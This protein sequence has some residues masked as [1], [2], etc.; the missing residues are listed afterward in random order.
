MKDESNGEIITEFVGIRSKMY[1]LKYQNQKE[2]KIAKGT[3]KSTVKNT[4][5][6]QDYKNCI[7][8]EETS[9]R[10]QNLIRSDAHTIYSVQV[11]K[12]ALNP[13]DD[14]RCLTDTLTSFPYGHYSLK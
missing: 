5:S 8:R 4:I 6:F 11:N 1:A 12:I 7:M 9:Y 3:K 10:K 14:K 2:K 13:Y